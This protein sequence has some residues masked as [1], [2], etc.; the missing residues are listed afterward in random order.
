MINISKAV[1]TDIN[2][3]FTV[4]SK[5]GRTEKIYKRKSYALSFCIDGQITY[6]HNGREIVSDKNHAVILP[7]DQTYTLHGDK[8]GSFPVINFQCAQVLCDTVVSVPIQNPSAYIKDFEQLKALSFFKENRNKMM[9]IFYDILYRLSSQAMN[10]SIITPAI[11]YLEKNYSNPYL[12]NAELARQCNIS[13][14][15]FRKMFVKHYKITP[16]QYIVNIRI[17][18]AKLLLAENSLKIKTVAELCGFSNQYHFCRVF[19]EKTGVT[20]TE[21]IRQN[22]IYKI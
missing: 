3:L 8:T 10:D 5:K 7:K 14:V 2:K 15:Y 11:D 20:P 18:K 13:E 19:K 17:S 9:S 12:T 1:V 6:N 22:R 21:Y 4:L 16:K